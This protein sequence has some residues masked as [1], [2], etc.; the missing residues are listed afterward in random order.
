MKNIVFILFISLLFIAPE[1]SFSQE[2]DDMYFT[3]KDRIK[4]KVTKK[5]TPA[6]VILSK[7]RKGQT[8]IN[9]SETV[10]AS[11]IN[12]YKFK[13]NINSISKNEN[14][15]SFVN[16][17]KYDRDNLYVSSSFEQT[18]LDVSNFMFGIRP[19]Y[20]S[21]MMDPFYM[22]MMR[23]YPMMGLYDYRWMPRT[24]WGMRKLAAFD[25]MMFFSNPYLSSMYPMFSPSLF[26]IHRAPSFS[27]YGC[28]DFLRHFP[29]VQTYNGTG[30]GIG[31]LPG[32]NHMYVNG[33]TSGNENNNSPVI[34]RGHR[35]GRGASINGENIDDILP[36][37]RLYRGRRESGITNENIQ[38]NSDKDIRNMTQNSFLRDRSS[39]IS[40]SN[41]SRSN[42]SSSLQNV[43]RRSRNQTNISNSQI[44]AI[45]DSFSNNRNRSSVGNSIYESSNGILSPNNVRRAS[46]SAPS[47]FGRSNGFSAFK[48]SGNT[49]NSS[50]MSGY[51]GRSSYNNSGSSSYSS[52]S[53]YSGGG[54]SGTAVSGGS[55]GG[56]SR[57]GKSN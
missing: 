16:S 32:F 51:G 6:D 4:K 21:M 10:N 47:G 11:L 36:D 3:S 50:G 13:A 30:A 18:I 43:S 14:S 57:G 12:K 35:S 7:Y 34:V 19:Y 46:Y 33:Y 23:G 45:N 55:S 52:G 44:N 56:S 17:L 15:R 54:S 42:R 22:D 27:L 31:H 26:S 40:R 25:P 37:N 9:S 29:W 41:E 24:L 2:N 38:R 8:R 39:G 48:N 28:N 53:S 5:V 49:N 1:I 20:Y